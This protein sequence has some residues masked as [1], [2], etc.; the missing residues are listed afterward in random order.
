[1]ELDKRLCK[2]TNHLLRVVMYYGYLNHLYTSVSQLILKVVWFLR[3]SQCIEVVLSERNKE[4]GYYP[5]QGF[6]GLCQDKLQGHF[7]D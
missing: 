5:R 2:V 1:M 6:I 4:N 7:K 3:G